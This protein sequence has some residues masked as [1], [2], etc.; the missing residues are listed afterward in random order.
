MFKVIT[1]SIVATFIGAFSAQAGDAELGEKDFK[2]CKACH[3]IA[4]PDGIVVKGGK[5]GPSL[6]GIVGAQAGSVAG[7][8]YGKDIV[9]AG[10]EGLIWTEELLVA[11]V[12][13]PK[14]FLTETLGKS[15]KSKMS[16]KVKDASNIIAYLATF[17]EDEII[18]ETT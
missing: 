11:Y 10:E 13:D 9:V 16:F 1:T 12:K 2:K 15:A 17:S 5:T 8:K 18:D 3:Q 7:Y 4:G 6:Y 14:K